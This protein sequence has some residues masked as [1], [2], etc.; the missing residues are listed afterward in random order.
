MDIHAE[1]RTK[2]PDAIK[3]SCNKRCKLT[4]DSL[5][6]YQ[7]TIVDADAYRK[8]CGIKGKLCDYFLFLTGSA[9][10]V[11]VAEMKSGSVDARIAVKQIISGAMES[12]KLVQLQAV[13]GFYPILLYGSIKHASELKVLGNAK[14]RFQGKDYSI[15]RKRCGAKLRDIMDTY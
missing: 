8:L 2:F 7:K 14:I 3:Q 10:T 12:E 1:L 11:V 15:I 4:L 5:S 6:S 9:L 13:S